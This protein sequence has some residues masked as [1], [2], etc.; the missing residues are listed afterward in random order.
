MCMHVGCAF[1]WA[2][3]V[4]YP[5]YYLDLSI[6]AALK[7]NLLPV[8]ALAALPCLIEGG[9]IALITAFYLR[10]KWQWAIMIGYVLLTLETKLFYMNYK[11]LTCNWLF[12][13]VSSPSDTC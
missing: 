7:K 11:A 9:I 5:H 1:A 12:S 6:P 8:L 4:L 13:V 3:V 2:H 10:L